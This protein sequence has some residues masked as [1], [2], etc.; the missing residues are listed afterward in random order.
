MDLSLFI[1]RNITEISWIVVIVSVL[2]IIFI[3]VRKK[4]SPINPILFK[5]T[6]KANLGFYILYAFLFYLF[7][8][9]A[10]IMF[11]T[12]NTGA[13]VLMLFFAIELIYYLG[14]A[15]I[16]NWINIDAHKRNLV[17]SNWG[18]KEEN[19]FQLQSNS[20]IGKLVVYPVNI[21]RYLRERKNHSIKHHS[22]IDKI[23]T[24]EVLIALFVLFFMILFAL[25]I[26]NIGCLIC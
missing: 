5:Y 19:F 11:S 2:L 21:I 24:V 12:Y 17:A 26:F 23:S 1:G 22:E 20:L 13:G 6:F 14:L 3:A 9:A 10:A 25:L 4:Y 8:M 16:I 18:I 15:S 7:L